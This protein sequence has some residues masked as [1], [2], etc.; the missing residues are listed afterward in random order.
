MTMMMCVFPKS[1]DF[2]IVTAKSSV[3]HFLK[4]KNVDCVFLL[5]LKKYYFNSNSTIV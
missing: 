2:S 4:K 3:F 5:T 1:N